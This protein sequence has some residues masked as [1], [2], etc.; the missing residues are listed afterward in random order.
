MG[1]RGAG[2]VGERV[3][4]RVRSGSDS[5][6]GGGGEGEE[7]WGWLNWMLGPAGGCPGAGSRDV[8]S[9]MTIS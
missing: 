8:G 6:G 9:G 4:D 2:G 5:G 3:R 7:G 1:W